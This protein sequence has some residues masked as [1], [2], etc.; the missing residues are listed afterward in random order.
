MPQGSARADAAQEASASATKAVTNSLACR[1]IVPPAGSGIGC[2]LD[3]DEGAGFRGR[4]FSKA[5]AAPHASL[6]VILSACVEWRFRTRSR[7]R[8]RT[9]ILPPDYEHEY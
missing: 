1:I 4:D 5:T 2:P 6:G 9:R 8:H 7:A 3:A